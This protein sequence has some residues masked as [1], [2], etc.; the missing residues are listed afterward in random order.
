MTSRYDEAE[1]RATI[2]RYQ[3]QPSVNEDIALR[4]YTSRLIGADG[5]LVLHGGGNTSVKT[6]I[7]DDLGVP[8]R[9]LAVK[10]SGWDLVD[11]EPKG[12][13]TVRLEPLLALRAL[14]A[15]SDE[16]MVNALRTRMLDAS[17]P[18]PSV[19]ALLHAFLPHRFIDHSHADALLALVDQP[20]GEKN[21]RAVYGNRLAVV[22]Y[23]MP[24]FALAKLAAEVYEANPEVE[25]LVLIKHGLF[26][27]GDTAR[28]SYERHVR[29]VEEAERF[30]VSARKRE[31]VVRSVVDVDYGRLAPVLRGRLGQAERHYVM[32]LR[33]SAKIRAFVDR[34][35]LGEIS[36]RGCVTPDH[37]IR[38]KR[39]PLVLDVAGVTDEALPAFVENAVEG[40]RAAY[41]TYVKTQTET[42]G[43]SVKSLDPDP[44]VVLVPGLGLIGIGA[45]LKAARIA[46]DL[47]EHTVDVIDAAEGVDR[48][49]VLSE[50]DL[51]DLE[52]WSLEQAKLG[53]SAPKPLAGRVVYITG[54]ARGIGAATAKAFAKQGAHLYLVD[55]EHD[56]LAAL[57][58]STG[59]AFET[60][61]V[62]DEAAVRASIA[63]CVAKFGGL[64][65]C[66]SNAG[67][68]PQ[69]A[70]HACD[71]ALLRQS[72]EINFFSHQWVASAV[73]HVLRAQGRG[74]FI[75]FNASKSAF[76][77][78]AELGPYAIAK[79]A[80]VALMKQ[81]ALEQGSV[82]IRVNA[83]NADRIR[84]GLLDQADIARRANA[85]G[86]E[87]DAYYK[88]NLLVREVVAEDVAE[89]FV[90]LALAPSTT[91]SIVTV[92]G[93][94]IAASPR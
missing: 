50:A 81:Y 43:L 22:P 61:D 62:T 14:P 49:E 71:S 4:V 3:G 66:I 8:T 57:A 47:Y 27:F 34:A 75:L 92:D 39:A 67:T 58:K 88:S 16:A 41:R 21:V 40:F 70:I 19:E 72:F 18:N 90:H 30:L 32:E 48:Y 51:F 79:A 2:A 91:A 44:R 1:A 64:D 5:A 74:G 33:T 35:D 59:A 84:T 83:V 63:R 93:G 76:N 69:S 85:R 13:P 54:A 10:G 9:V 42:R 46:A 23:V 53:K 7:E 20:E 24:G 77:P 31:P 37:V 12:L 36:Q 78:G 80:V 55:R 45:D 94:N 29:A 15:M 60:L 86:L 87:L 17:A 89:A 25:G 56:A 65:G 82:G 73:T 26:T 52:Y 11:L 38:T 6:T 68:A 28:E